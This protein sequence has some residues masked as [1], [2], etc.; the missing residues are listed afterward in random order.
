MVEVLRDLLH[1]DA[2]LGHV[3]GRRVAQRVITGRS[4]AKGLCPLYPSKRTNSRQ[5]DLSALCQ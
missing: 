4:D 1:R 5:L 3:D 2:V